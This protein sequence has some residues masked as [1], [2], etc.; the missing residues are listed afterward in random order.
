MSMRL[1]LAAAIVSI[2]L[3][4][5][6]SSNLITGDGGRSG[7]PADMSKLNMARI[8]YDSEGGMGE[9]YYAYDGRVWARW[10][11][12]FPEGDDNFGR[13]LSQLTRIPVAKFASSRMLTAPDLGDFP[14]LYMS[15]PGYMVVSAQEK[16][17]FARYLTNG[18]FV[19]VDDFWGDAEWQQLADVMREVLPGREW[20]VLPADHPIFH[21]VFDLN[22]GMPQIPAL[23][24]ASPGGSTAEP[25][26]AH[27]FPAGSLD[28]PEMRAWVDDDGRIMVLATHNTD[29][30]DGWEREAYG[31][32]YFETFST[33]SY[34]VGVNVVVYAMTH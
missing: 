1:A 28:N 15:D 29:V 14:L 12:D 11:T 9:A 33:K 16:A 34:M 30:G 6:A 27:K 20:R 26:G 22:E 21:T 19:W 23:P 3:G 2:S 7:T 10:E 13:R 24:F 5:A 31:E 4:A 8:I 25:P 18:G 17:A 32:W